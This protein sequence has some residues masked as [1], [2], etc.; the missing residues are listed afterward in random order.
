MKKV[1]KYLLIIIFGY[2]ILS[3]VYLEFGRP[4]KIGLTEYNDNLYEKDFFDHSFNLTMY[5]TGYEFRKKEIFCLDSQTI[6][7]IVEIIFSQE[8]YW[9]FSNPYHLSITFENKRD[10][11]DVVK[12]LQKNGAV[13]QKEKTIIIRRKHSEEEG[14]LYYW[15][16]GNQKLYT[17][18]NG[19]EIQ[20]IDKLVIWK[21]MKPSALFSYH[22]YLIKSFILRLPD[23]CQPEWVKKIIPRIK[24]VN[25]RK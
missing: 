4:F 24:K 11:E 17:N 10:V 5:E 9:A 6:T 18:Y 7:G 15:Q 25:Q 22:L 20:R 23:F 2:F 3:F 13:L 12:Y 16:I 19:R 8:P 1:V 21:E 14:E